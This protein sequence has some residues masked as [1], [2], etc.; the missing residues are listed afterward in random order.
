MSE[1]TQTFRDVK[2]ALANTTLL[3]H[4]CSDIT[5]SMVIDA[6]KTSTGAVLHQHFSNHS[7]PL[8]FFSKNLQPWEMRY[9]MF[10]CELIAA[11]L[12]V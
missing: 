10:G 2:T 5:F 7:E 4:S 9:S 1:V 6:S 11:N 12:A 8:A 3:S